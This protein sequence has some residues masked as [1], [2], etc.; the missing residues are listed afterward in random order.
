MIRQ[1]Q[2]LKSSAQ[3]AGAD[4][5]STRPSQWVRLERTFTFEAA[6]RLPN[7][8][9]GH[10]CAR[11]HGHSFRID[12]VCEGEI[13]PETGWLIDFADIKRAVNPLIEQVD[14]HYLNEIK[15]LE[16]PTAEN[17]ARWFWERLKPELLPLSRII[18]AET[19]NG[20]CEYAG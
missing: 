11:L 2:D 3:V 12:V 4:K 18:V 9:K 19:C 1:A 8:P 5:L 14:H 16:N 17:I 6:H 20:R 7:V 10:K 13:N 15:G